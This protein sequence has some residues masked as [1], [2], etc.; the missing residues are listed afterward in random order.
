MLNKILEVFFRKEKKN[1]LTILTSIEN[2]IVPQRK[3]TIKNPERV[4]SQ[5]VNNTVLS[6]YFKNLK[7]LNVKERFNV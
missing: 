4:L 1:H 5:N 7:G 3:R 6:G 2:R